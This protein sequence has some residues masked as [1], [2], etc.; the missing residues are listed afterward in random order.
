MVKKFIAVW[1]D[2]FFSGDQ[3][4]GE[5]NVENNVGLEF[6]SDDTGYDQDDRNELDELFIG[7]PW[8]SDYPSHSV[9]RIS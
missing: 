9:I 6:F 3:L 4:N 8:R 7:Q 1:G 5:Y 2:D